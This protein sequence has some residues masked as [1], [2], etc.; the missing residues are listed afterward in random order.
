MIE[1]KITTN[2]KDTKKE[3]NLKD[4]PRCIN[5]S[6][7]CSLKLDYI[8]NFE[9][10]IIYEC[11]NGHSGNI[12]LEDYMNKYNIF[13]EICSNCRKRQEEEEEELFYCSVCKVFICLSCIKYHKGDKHSTT[14]IRRYDSLCTKHKNLFSYYCTILE[15]I[16]A[17]IA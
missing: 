5:C 14:N 7:I 12:S 17:F 2:D 1:K 11:E 9:P 10:R 15:K 4:I 3:F 16:F 6:L 13:N 8:G